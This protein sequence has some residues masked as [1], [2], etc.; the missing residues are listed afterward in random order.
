[1]LR[2]VDHRRVHLTPHERNGRGGFDYAVKTE[3]GIA[4]CHGWAIGTEE[5]AV[6]EAIEHA[7]DVYRSRIQAANQR[8]AV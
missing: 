4:V 2:I 1:M 5:Q 7:D 8:K 3:A 6:R